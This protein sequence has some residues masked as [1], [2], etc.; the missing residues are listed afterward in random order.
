MTPEQFKSWR[1]EMGFTQD[2]AAEALG[3][4]KATIGNYDKGIRREDGRPVVI[5]KTVALACAALMAGIAPYG[6]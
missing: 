1:V 4:S 3:V 5:P 6:E 2:E